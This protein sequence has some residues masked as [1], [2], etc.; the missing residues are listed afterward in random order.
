MAQ[1]YCQIHSL[2]N[3]GPGSFSPP[4]KVDSAVVRLIP[5]TFDPICQ[6]TELLSRIVLQAFQH[7]RKTIHNSLKGM[8]TDE[9][10]LQVHVPPQERAENIT[11]KQFVQLA[12]ILHKKTL[13]SPP[14][15]S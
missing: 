4:P 13:L 14:T 2:F 8:V 12:N 3:V 9:E 1:Y 5:R 6:N 10:L 15:G 11:V 7:R